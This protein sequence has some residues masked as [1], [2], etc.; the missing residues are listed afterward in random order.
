M[1]FFYKKNEGRPGPIHTRPHQKS[2]WFR[3]GFRRFLG[4]WSSDPSLGA[5]HGPRRMKQ[6]LKPE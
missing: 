2:E 5:N 1:L 4:S 6:L 3:Q